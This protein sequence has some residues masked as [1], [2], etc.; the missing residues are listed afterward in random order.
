MRQNP[1]KNELNEFITNNYKYRAAAKNPNL[2]DK[3]MKMSWTYVY[4]VIQDP[5]AVVP[6]S[7][8]E[9][10]HSIFQAIVL[11]DSY[12]DVPEETAPAEQTRDEILAPPIVEKADSPVI[13][14]GAKG[15]AMNCAN[16]KVP[17]IG[18]PEHFDTKFDDRALRMLRYFLREY[19]HEVYHAAKEGEFFGGSMWKT[20]PHI[21]THTGYKRKNANAGIK[22][23]VN[24]GIIK[25]DPKQRR[26]KNQRYYEIDYPRL[27]EHILDVNCEIPF[28]DLYPFDR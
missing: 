3:S 17:Y 7:M 11:G 8:T 14:K 9:D 18:F 15:M 13:V 10:V 5:D 22:Q 21:E 20:H 28:Q 25:L 1:S 12:E 19:D 23:L 4:N 27:F 16:N 6:Q 2:F 24:S 26:G